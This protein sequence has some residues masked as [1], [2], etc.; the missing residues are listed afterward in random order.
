MTS[1]KAI[2]Y[3]E[4]GADPAVDRIVTEHSDNRTT[5]VA[6]PELSVAVKVAIK[7]VEDGVDLIELCGS[8][9]PI[10]H[11]KVIE[12]V[13]S[14]VPVGSIL[15][16]FESLTSAAEYKAR[17]EAGESM[18]AAF[19]FV[20]DGAD[21]TVDR[22]VKTDKNGNRIAFVAVSEPSAAAKV[23]V[24]LVDDGIGL[25]EL[26]GGFGPKWAAQVIEAIDKRVPVGFRPTSA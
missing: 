1:R 17:F 2:I 9:G 13:G 11:A 24:D 5:I 3:E 8:F 4:A 12:A 15:Y 23:A 26:Y 10:W 6:V 25:I 18:T 7:L 20:E 22:T 21:P 19:I 16:G 14:Q